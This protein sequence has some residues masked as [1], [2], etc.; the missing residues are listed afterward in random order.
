M[1]VRLKEKD[2]RHHEMPAYHSLLE[3]MDAYLRALGEQDGEQER[4]SV[5]S[6]RCLDLSRLDAQGTAAERGAAVAVRVD[7]SEHL[8][9]QLPQRQALPFAPPSRVPGPCPEEIPASVRSARRR[10][11][12]CRLTGDASQVIDCQQL[13]VTGNPFYQS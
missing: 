11:R 8:L 2:G 5:R 12:S 4:H 3:Y 1:G 7:Q 6:R 9:A 10:L 13:T